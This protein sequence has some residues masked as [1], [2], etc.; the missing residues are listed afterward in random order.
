ML[1]WI[2]DR[3]HYIAQCQKQ[4]WMLGGIPIVATSRDG[5]N[6]SSI[7]IDEN[8]EDSILNQIGELE[9]KVKSNTKE[10]KIEESVIN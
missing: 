8:N 9:N 5:E 2:A 3:V 10:S 1:N 4:I 7:E 6:I